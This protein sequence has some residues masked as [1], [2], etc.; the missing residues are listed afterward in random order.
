M[1]DRRTP[2]S[3]W[4][5]ILAQH[6]PVLRNA[7]LLS[8]LLHLLI[9][10]RNTQHPNTSDNYCTHFALKSHLLTSSS[11]LILATK[12]E[13]LSRKCVGS[14]PGCPTCSFWKNPVLK[15]VLEKQSHPHIIKDR[16][17]LSVTI[18]HFCRVLNNPSI[19]HFLIFIHSQHTAKQIKTDC[20]SVAQL[21]LQCNDLLGSH[22]QDCGGVYRSI[23]ITF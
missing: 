12:A 18:H 11:A 13:T 19:K 7:G 5:W 17:F 8:S 10:Q 3:G 6:I 9:P 22:A 4:V 1:A 14:K 23:H 2:S 20:L 15:S 16:G 21:Y